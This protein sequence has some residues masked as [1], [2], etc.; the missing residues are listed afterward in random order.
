MPCGRR[1]ERILFFWWWNNKRL[2]Q[3]KGSWYSAMAMSY[4]LFF[5]SLGLSYGL[6]KWGFLSTYKWYFGSLLQR[7]QSRWPIS[8][9]VGNLHGCISFETIVWEACPLGRSSNDFL[10]ISIRTSDVW[11]SQQMGLEHGV[12]L[13]SHA[14][15]MIMLLMSRTFSILDNIQL[16]CS[17]LVLVWLLVLVTKITVWLD[18]IRHFWTT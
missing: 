10:V 8:P 18:L 7:I 17:L 16:Q 14:C 9:S 13:K 6:L 11:N 12:P 1:R 5:F 4:N 15:C 2:R 3:I